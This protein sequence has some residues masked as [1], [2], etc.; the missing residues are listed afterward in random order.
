MLMKGRSQCGQGGGLPPRPLSAVLPALSTEPVLTKWL[1]PDLQPTTSYVIRVEAW[2]GT[3]GNG[4]L[5]GYTDFTITTN[6]TT[7]GSNPVFVYPPTPANGATG[8]TLNPTIRV[9]P[10]AGCGDLVQLTI[11]VF[12]NTTGTRVQT[13]TFNSTPTGSQPSSYDYYV[14]PSLLP[15][16]AYTVRATYVVNN[17]SDS[18]F[19]E[20]GFTTGNFL[21]QTRPVSYY[22][23]GVETLFLNGAYRNSLTQRFRAFPVIGADPGSY[24]WQFDDD[25]QFGSPVEFLR[26]SDDFTFSATDPR[27][28]SGAL[29]YVRVRATG[30]GT[31]GTYPEPGSPAIVSYHHPLFQPQMTSPVTTDWAQR[32]QHQVNYSGECQ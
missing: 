30:N 15:S 26:Q 12:Q 23:N 17:L 24:D 29:Y 32:N 9:A 11:E 13:V 27:F 10:F 31:S 4:V 18:F 22:N 5:L 1:W 2:S 6:N 21:Q 25:P 7:P 28:V 8:V 20:T 19:S 3:G 16:T 14:S